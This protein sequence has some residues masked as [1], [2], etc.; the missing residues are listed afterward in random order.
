MKYSDLISVKKA[1]DEHNLDSSTD[2]VETQLKGMIECV[3]KNYAGE[4]N[5]TLTNVLENQYEI[6]KNGFSTL[7]Y[8][9]E[10]IKNEVDKNID[11]KRDYLLSLSDRYYKS[12]LLKTS[13]EILD[14]HKSNVHYE[15][16]RFPPIIAKHGSWKHAAFIIHPGRESFIESMIDNDPLYLVDQNFELLEPAIARFNEVYQRRLRKYIIDEQ[17]KQ[18]ILSQLPNG[19]FGLCVVYHYFN[20][21]PFEIIQRYLAEIYEKLKP[22]GVLLFT[23]NNCETLSGVRMVEAGRRCYA[24]EYLIKQEIFKIGYELIHSE[25]YDAITGPGTWM[26]IKKPGE[27]TSIRGSQTLAKILPK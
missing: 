17:S 10:K 12:E 25:D 3:S 6:V 1:L 23:Y 22:G 7:K 26:E 21:R 8:I 16:S 15:T 24:T 2:I 14:I 5:K 19:Q 4:K 11:D 20:F 18:A 9:A 27:L 13:N